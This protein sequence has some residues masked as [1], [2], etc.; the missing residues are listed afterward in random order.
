[1]RTYILFIF[2]QHYIN[3][4]NERVLKTELSLPLSL[5]YKV[6]RHNYW[7]WRH[8]KNK[9][10]MKKDSYQGKQSGYIIIKMCDCVVADSLINNNFYIAFYSQRVQRRK[11]TVWIPA[12]SEVTQ[13]LLLCSSWTKSCK[14]LITSMRPICPVMFKILHLITLTVLEDLCK[15]CKSILCSFYMITLP[16]PTTSSVSNFVHKAPQALISL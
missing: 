14:F 6:L 5:G 16:I 9:S 3:L 11:Y 8:I 7:V 13:I 15:L 10:K 1:M 2:Y 4:V 12:T